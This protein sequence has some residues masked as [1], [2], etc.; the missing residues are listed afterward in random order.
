V[1]NENSDLSVPIGGESYLRAVR[2]KY[3]AIEIW[4]ASDRWLAHVKEWI[5]KSISAWQPALGLTENS[6]VL[7]AGSG[8]ESYNVRPGVVIDCDIADRKLVG[9]PR[10]VAGD[11][12]K[13][14]LA[15]GSIDTCICVGSVV[16]YV[17][18]LPQAIAEIGRVVK[19]NGNLVLEFESSCSLEYIGTPHFGKDVSQVSTFYI[20]ENEN[21]WIYHVDHMRKLLRDA[22]FEVVA[23]SRAHFLAPLVQGYKQDINYAARFA[24]FDKYVK[25]LPF[26]RKHSANIMFLCQRRR[27][28][29]D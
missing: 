17:R 15:A 21:I 8:D 20:Y 16:N 6:M 25:W 1:P 19:D 29:P 9:M 22:G 23:E 2:E 13:L 7:N 5:A 27:I 24:R 10:G 4:P 14:P 12:T 28:R 11:L 3:N 18:E 26:L